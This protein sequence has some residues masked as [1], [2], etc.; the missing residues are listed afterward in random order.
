MKLKELLSHYSEEA[1][2]QIA[3]DKI[4]AIANVRLPRTVLERE[5]AA[6]LSS[7]SYVAETMAA[8]HPPTYVF[9]KLLMESPAG[10][11]TAHGFKELVLKRTD[12]LTE[13]ASEQSGEDASRRR[14]ALY[15]TVLKA[16]WEFENR[17]NPSE[18]NLLETLRSE[19][20]ISMRE[21]LLLEHHRDVRP[22]WDSPRAYESARNYLLARGLILTHGNQFVLPREVLVQI[23]RY[24]GMELPDVLY[25]ELLDTLTIGH[26]RA[27]LEA[28]N[29]PL[30]GSKAERLNRIIG[31][32]VPP[33]GALDVLNIDELKDFSR[34]RRLPVSAPKAELIGQLINSFEQE[35]RA[36]QAGTGPEDGQDSLSGNQLKPEVFTELLGRLTGS[37]LHEILDGL[38][39]PRSGRKHERIARIAA[40]NANEASVLSLLRRREL[41]QLCERLGLGVSGLKDDLIERIL[42]AAAEPADEHSDAAAV[43]HLPAAETFAAIEDGTAGQELTQA[44]PASATEL[45]AIRSRFP[46]LAS[47]QQL[48]LALLYE[49]RSLTERDIRRLTLRHGLNWLLPKAHMA[50]LLRMLARNGD[51]PIRIRSTGSANIYEWFEAPATPEQQLDSLAARDVIEALRHGVV[52]ERHSELLFVGQEA[53]RAHLLEQLDYVAANRSAFKFIRGAYGAG[54]SFLLSWFREKALEAGFAVANVRVGSELSMADLTE[55]YGGLM[56]GL[57]IPEKRGAS[58]IADIIEAW[59]LAVQRRTE[60]IEGIDGNDPG[61][62]SELARLV[63]ERIRTELTH[64]ADHDPGLTSA[65][66]AF[67]TSRLAGDEDTATSAVAWIRGDR[68]LPTAALRKIGIRGTLEADQVF[69]RLRA[70]LELIAATHLRGLVILIDELEL[71]R[72]R[73][74]K[75]V[76]DQAYETLRSL[77]DETGENR[78]PG[79]LLL[80][81]GTDTF[82]EDRQYGIASYEALLHRIQAPEYGDAHRSMRQPIIQLEGFDA[83]RLRSIAR[84]TRAVHGLAYGWP[85]GERLSDNDVDLIVDRWSAFGGEQIDRLP[86]PFLRQFVYLLDLCEENPDLEPRELMQDP[87]DDPEASEALLQL[88]MS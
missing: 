68:S 39:L 63:D 9:L 69:P 41:K 45:P 79:T 88:V 81:T 15:R 27:I 52:P 40:S 44:Q 2:D 72:R 34:S 57:R 17:I 83:A 82:F 56:D 36:E 54:K 58:G 7:F 48:V 75:R 28:N 85:A 70:L 43:N 12:E 37:Q 1:L 61:K 6:T 22:I 38:S 20:G 4:D 59:L 74:H 35:Q 87:M 76:R 55:F 51:S 64:L 46:D 65:L 18:A 66:Q 71:V 80:S 67:Y 26:L 42:E 23:R 86:R 60:Q 19:L 8:S 29:L 73:P 33:S 32:M 62:R 13:Q 78:L 77:L 5:I 50:E 11:V 24:W 10:S 30:S 21:H 16:A 84:R 3:R 31:N 25:R 14:R 53:A 47:D 49:A